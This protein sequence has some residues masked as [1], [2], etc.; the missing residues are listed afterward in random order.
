MVYGSVQ[1]VDVLM[2]SGM[3]DEYQLWLHPVIIG[4][5]IPLFKPGVF[6]QRTLLQLNLV[7]LEKFV[8]GVVLLRYQTTRD[9]VKQ[10]TRKQVPRLHKQ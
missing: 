8:C 10:S 6:Q 1:L 3:V 2:Q 7:K 9:T 5:G 4:K